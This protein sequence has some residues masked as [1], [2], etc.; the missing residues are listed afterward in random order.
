MTGTATAGGARG[1]FG[2]ASTLTVTD[3]QVIRR[4]D[5]AV[6]LISYNTRQVGQ[7]ME[8]MVRDRAYDA[9]EL[10]FTY[11]LRTLEL[12]G[13]PLIAIPVFPN[14]IFRHAAIFVNRDSGIAEPGDLR[15]RKVGELHRYGH[16]AGIWAKGILSDEYGVPA[17][18]MTH[19]VGA[20]DKPGPA[21]NA[22]KYL[23]AEAGYQAAHVGAR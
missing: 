21:A 17:D 1:G 10:G 6:A 18:S 8:R 19:Y 22:A 20:M 13:A 23:A 9:A 7:I 2:S 3:A 12:A 4:E 5:S 11:Y 16:D 15:G 14:R